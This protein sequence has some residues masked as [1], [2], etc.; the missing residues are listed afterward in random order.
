MLISS[1]LYSIIC[2]QCKTVQTLICCVK[3][4]E[5]SKG[6]EIITQMWSIY[7]YSCIQMQKL[8]HYDPNYISDSFNMSSKWKYTPKCTQTSFTSILCFFHMSLCFFMRVRIER[9]VG[10]ELFVFY[11]CENGMQ[12]FSTKREKRQ[13]PLSQPPESSSLCSALILLFLCL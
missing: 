1:P 13:K 8:F 5:W 6:S 12:P 10:G 3:L 2:N 11:V 9:I 4:L 7:H